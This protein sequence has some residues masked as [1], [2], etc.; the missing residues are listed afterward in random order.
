MILTLVLFLMLQY[1]GGI[2]CPV[3]G[4]YIEEKGLSRSVRRYFDV[5]RKKCVIRER[6]REKRKGQWVRISKARYL[7]LMKRRNEKN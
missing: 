5:K 7:K 6:F 1:P 4:Q 3:S 2:H